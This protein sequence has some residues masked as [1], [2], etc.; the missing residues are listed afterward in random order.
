MLSS[1]W[2]FIWVER[3]NEHRVSFVIC[4]NHGFSRH[5]FG[6]LLC[7]INL[8]SLLK[9]RRF[10]VASQNRTCGSIWIILNVK[11]SLIFVTIFFIWLVFH[12]QNPHFTGF[13]SSKSSF[14][15]LVLIEIINSLA[16]HHQKFYSISSFLNLLFTC[17]SSSKSLIHLFFMIK[18]FIWFVCHLQNYPLI[19]FYC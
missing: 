18:I 15:W 17:F 19:F 3:V 16:F 13:S 12:L 5:F 4:S 1:S 8:L 11:F 7:A 9:K 2:V 10:F 6:A 14:D